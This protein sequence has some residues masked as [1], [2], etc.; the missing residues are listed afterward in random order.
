[1]VSFI[2]TELL[3]ASRT[4]QASLPFTQAQVQGPVAGAWECQ[5]SMHY[6]IFTR[7][8]SL[9]PVGV[10]CEIPLVSQRVAKFSL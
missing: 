2:F 10:D 7:V 3:R 6:L 4:F 5:A 9:E 8:Q 1:M